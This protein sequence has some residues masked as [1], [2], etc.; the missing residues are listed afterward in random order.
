MFACIYG[1]G[2]SVLACAYAFSPRVEETGPDT[3]I[4]EID[5][6][7]RLFGPPQAIAEAIARQAAELSV[8]VNVGVASNP[9]AALCAARGFPGIRI[10]RNGDDLAGLSV[11]LLSPS[12]E[13]LETLDRW[14]IRSFRDL[15]ALPE[16]GVSERLGAPG[17]RL[18]KLAAGCWERPLNPAYPAP[19][20][21]E[22]ME[23]EHPIS[24]LEPLSFILARLLNQLCRKLAERGLATNELR[25]T[26]QLAGGTD[27][28]RSLRLPVP[29][30]HPRAFL[31]LMQL[32][33][34]KH[35]P[36]APIESI[37]IAGE[38]AKPRRHQEGLFTPQAPEPEKLEI[39]LARIEALVGEG[40]VGSPELLNTHRPGAF[41][42]RK[43]LTGGAGP[44]HPERNSQL[45]F[46]AYRPPKAAQVQI[47]GGNPVRVTASGVNGKI[48][49]AAGPWR[50]SGDWWSAE[51]WVR[52][53]WD[54][55]VAGGALYRIY[56]EGAAWF[57]EGC[58]D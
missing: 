45:A 58:Y 11:E 46:R 56:Q 18:Q 48:V 5:G 54:I 44:R 33:L 16:T 37:R 28:T 34:E 30:Q 15:A 57:I 9:D 49:A 24:L 53:E 43:A 32:D 3:A 51:P 41:A 17:V 35:P 21:E 42:V 10:I 52:D 39:T 6:L 20:F 47:A 29:M 27:H 31:R 55:E 50:T 40:N 2:L 14:G 25:L 13:I 4:F 36:K 26:F 1:N 22:S 7:R 38:P 12:P 23:L 8:Q 19:V